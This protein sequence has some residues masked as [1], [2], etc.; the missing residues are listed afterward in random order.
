MFNHHYDKVGQTYWK[1]VEAESAFVVKAQR[2][3]PEG[4]AVF[5]Y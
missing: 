4:D 5:D 3:I 1:Y 2:G